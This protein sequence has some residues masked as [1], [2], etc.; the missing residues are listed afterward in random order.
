MQFFLCKNGVKL[1]HLKAMHYGIP[2]NIVNYEFASLLFAFVIFNSLTSFPAAAMLYNFPAQ[3]SAFFS[4][5]EVFRLFL[6]LLG[7]CE[8]VILKKITH[9]NYYSFQENEVHRIMC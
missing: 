3:S 7:M 4:S 1:P 8:S 9:Q 6:G 5:D 2:V